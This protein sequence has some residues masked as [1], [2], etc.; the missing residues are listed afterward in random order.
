MSLDGLLRAGRLALADLRHEWVL[1]LCLILAIAAAMAPLVLLLGLKE[2]VITTMRDRLVQDPYN[3]QLVPRVTQTY[4]ADFFDALS[5][6]GDVDFVIPSILAGASVISARVPDSGGGRGELV[7]LGLIPTASGDPLMV[8]NGV[9]EPPGDGELVLTNEAAKRLRLAAGA[10]GEF[11]VY[12][13]GRPQPVDLSV[14]AVLPPRAGDDESVYAPLGFVMDVEQFK[15]GFAIPKRGWPG[16][17]AAPAH[18][19]DGILAIT[20]GPLARNERL[21]LRV[22]VGV[23]DVTELTPSAVAELLGVQ[24]PEQLS[25]TWL[26]ARGK[27]VPPS[28][29]YR[30]QD[31]LR[32]LGGLVQPIVRP[33]ELQWQEGNTSQAQRRRVYFLSLDQ[34]EAGFL[35]VAAPPWGGYT[36]RTGVPSPI[37]LLTTTPVSS[38]NG[39]ELQGILH[40][41]ARPNRTG[42]SGSDGRQLEVAATMRSVVRRGEDWGTALWAPL[43]V[44]AALRGAIDRGLAVSADGAL[45][46]ATPDF[47]SFRLYARSIDQVL[48]LE[49]YLDSEGV[50]TFTQGRQIARMQTLDA[51]LSRV[52][53]ILGLVGGVGA[54]AALGASL[55]AA[56]QRKTV[57]FGMLRLMGMSRAGL[58]SIPL[59]Q[60]VCLAGF[61]AL[62]ALATYTILAQFMRGQF[63]QVLAPDAT[64][65][66][67][68]GVYALLLIA[69][70]IGAALVS[71]LVAALQATR[72]DPAEAL[73][74]E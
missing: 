52:L 58:F 39:A 5:S 72:I 69:G 59:L 50:P 55:Y 14:V 64:I 27:T 31:R 51:A 30:A 13:S 60:A 20:A 15:L 16:D 37:P 10:T 62:L 2:G 11:L 4:S 44:G 48:E 54:T 8:D 45:I 18:A 43:D 9:L 28:V 73:R 40:L 7:N 67:L 12:R 57:H 71:A 6:R 23:T 49:R 68:P 21:R 17:V 25:Y 19:F 42:G 34:A 41:P 53:W 36:Q 70:A 61:G 32:P 66:E 63:S 24:V 3:R 46:A 1:T 35:G 74:A 29:V 65:S 38:G 26:E 56:V 47:R 33:V 22:G